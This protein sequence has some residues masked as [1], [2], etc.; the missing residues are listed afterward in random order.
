MRSFKA[1]T[2]GKMLDQMAI[3]TIALPITMLG[4]AIALWECVQN[5]KRASVPEQNVVGGTASKMT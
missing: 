3:A 1:A 2:A 4:T 5:H